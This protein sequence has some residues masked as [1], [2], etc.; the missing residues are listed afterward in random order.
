MLERVHNNNDIKRGKRRL[1][2]SEKK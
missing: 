2:S 1:L